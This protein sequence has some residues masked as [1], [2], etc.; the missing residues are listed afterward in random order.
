VLLLVLLARGVASVA[1]RGAVVDDASALLLLLLLL[2]LL[3]ARRARARAAARERMVVTSGDALCCVKADYD[4]IESV[5][6][7]LGGEWWASARARGAVWGGD[8][9]A[10]ESV[11]KSRGI[12]GL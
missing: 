6:G 1:A 4:A 7:F 10:R 11:L 9:S 5:I 8:Q 12:A 2:L 3:V